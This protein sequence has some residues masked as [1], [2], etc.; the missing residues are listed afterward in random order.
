M[1]IVDAIEEAKEAC[2]LAVNIVEVAIDMGADPAEDFSRP[3]AEEKETNFG[4]GIERVLSGVEETLSL[5]LEMGNIVRRGPIE[6]TGKTDEFD[7]VA[8]GADGYCGRKVA[9]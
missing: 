3:G 7:E 8:A 4:V 6:V 9:R 5:N 1:R 2:P